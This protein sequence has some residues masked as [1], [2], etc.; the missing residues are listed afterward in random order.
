MRTISLLQPP[1]LV[2]GN[3][4]TSQ[5]RIDF[6]ATGYRR[7][8]LMIAPPV[9]Q[10]VENEIALIVKE[11]VEVFVCDDTIQEPSIEDFE[12]MLKLAQDFGADSVA[13]IGGGSVLDLA[14]MVA[15][16][17]HSSLN[18]REVIGT[19][20]LAKRSTWL[21]CL[22]TTSGTGSEVSPNSIL[23][24]KEKNLKIGTVSPHLVPDATYIDPLL[25]MGVPPRI[26]AETGMDALSHCVEAYTNKFAHPVIDVYALEGIRQVSRNLLTAVRDG[27]NSEA[28]EALSLG[29]YYGGL[30]LGPV[31]TTA[32]HALSYPLGG[33][34][35]VP[36]GL[37]N[38]ILMPAVMEFNM[39]A[40]PERFADVAVALG[41]QPAGTPIETA[42]R[43]VE[44]IRTML[45]DCGL[46]STL[47]ELG[48]PPS[49]ID[50][51]AASAVTVQRLLK[52]NV[53]EVGIEDA[54]SI[55]ESIK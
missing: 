38:A 29:S 13:G 19:Q 44:I 27:S 28:R 55:Y 16:M 34:F 50:A 48:I 10:I 1:K 15:A 14:K 49:A 23:L 47:S 17:L 2:F 26:T 32:I 37:S 54:K 25:T 41:A 46:P 35:H 52:N 11:G 45:R 3:G 30:C 7:L 9:R 53:R 24:D 31:N 51:M 4:S 5:F 6:I 33:T 43:G 36:H 12:R 42:R 22:P 8:F 20:L 40:A 21:A 39:V 18:I